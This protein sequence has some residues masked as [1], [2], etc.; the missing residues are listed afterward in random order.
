MCETPR[1]VSDTHRYYVHEGETSIMTYHE[2]RAQRD[3]GQALQVMGEEQVSPWGHA[4]RSWKVQTGASFST[5]MVRVLLLLPPPRPPLLLLLL[6]AGTIFAIK[7]I[8]ARGDSSGIVGLLVAWLNTGWAGGSAPSVN[9]PNV[10]F[11]Q[12]NGASP[13]PTCP[14]PSSQLA[15]TFH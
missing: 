10:F 7:F 8:L 12:P 15:A 13:C 6:P 5:A 3:L 14:T 1:V 2:R 11:G 4:R 9:K